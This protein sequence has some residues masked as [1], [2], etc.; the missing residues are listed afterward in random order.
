M[1]RRA[2]AVGC[3]AT[4]AVAD[5]VIFRR[6][7][8]WL[9]V[10]FFDHPAHVATAALAALALGPRPREWTAGLLVGSL[11][12]DLDHV[13]LA[14]S[15]VHPT[16][17]DPRPVTHCLLAVAPVA[18]IATLRDDRRLR[19]A[20]WGMLAHFARDVGVGTG[21]PLLWPV[22]RRSFRVPY[23]VYAAGCVALA[24]RAVLGANLQNHAERANLG[25][26]L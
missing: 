7:L 23:P 3:L 6:R 2:A 26:G 10:G 5:K 21:V 4:V 11:L 13:P 15:R 14:V 25:A 12:P 9:L 22:T 18:V 16:L 24:L 19:G 17:D 1:N 8:P 20:A